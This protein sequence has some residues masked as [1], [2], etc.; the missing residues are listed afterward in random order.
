MKLKLVSEEKDSHDFMM[1]MDD[2]YEMVA[3]Q[4]QC[5]PQF[6]VSLLIKWIQILAHR[7]R[8]QNRIL[9]YYR[10]LST[11]IV[12]PQIGDVH[13]VDDD[14]AFVVGQTKQRLYYR[15]L[16]RSGASDNPHLLTWLN[17]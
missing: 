3:Y 10:N 9:R 2:V 5:S 17:Q 12:Q 6:I 14:L 4:S 7:A 13:T 11:Q 8:E 15:T 16:A 1:M